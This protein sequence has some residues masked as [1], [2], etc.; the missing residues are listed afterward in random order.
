M[1]NTPTRATVFRTSCPRCGHEVVAIVP[2]RNPPGK[3]R[4]AMIAWAWRGNPIRHCPDT[5]CRHELPEIS[6]ERFLDAVG[7]FD[8]PEVCSE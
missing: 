6:V 8:P 1:P 3:R 2:P 5:K 7:A 4:S